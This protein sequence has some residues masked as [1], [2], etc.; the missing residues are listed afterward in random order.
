[1]QRNG[2]S[3]WTDKTLHNLGWSK[4]DALGGWDSLSQKISWILSISFCHKLQPRLLQLQDVDGCDF[5]RGR[6]SSKC[7]CFLAK[8]PLHR[9]KS[10][11][12]SHFG[13]L[14]CTAFLLPFRFNTQLYYTYIY[15]FTFGPA[16]KYLHQDVPAVLH[17]AYRCRALVE[18]VELRKA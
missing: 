7:I 13:A 10:Y 12:G 1:M 5:R 2:A 17:I 9:H 3:W 8:G 14:Q 16:I 15:F 4:R 6:H 18:L 11:Q